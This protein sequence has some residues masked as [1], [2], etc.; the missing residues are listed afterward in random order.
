ME[1]AKNSLHLI[2]V[3]FCCYSPLKKECLQ[4]SCLDHL[5]PLIRLAV[6]FHFHNKNSLGYSCYNRSTLK[7]G[8]NQPVEI[9]TQKSKNRVVGLSQQGGTRDKMGLLYILLWHSPTSDDKIKTW[10]KSI[11]CYWPQQLK[12]FDKQEH[13]ALFQTTIRD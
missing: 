2:I 7:H 3:F 1:P 10:N 4:D 5:F 6:L 12:S 9:R 8:G 11:T 13:H